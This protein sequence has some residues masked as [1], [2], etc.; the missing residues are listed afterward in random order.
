[1][2]TRAPTLLQLAPPIL[3]CALV[4]LLMPAR[5]L[6]HA[7]L[8]EESPS[9]GA[10]LSTSPQRIALDFTE[11]L[12]RDL[13]EATLLD[14]ESDEPIAAH[15]DAP[16]SKRLVLRPLGPLGR[17]PYTVHWRTVSTVDGHTLEGSFSFG[18]RTAAIGGEGQVVQS[19]LARDGWLRIAARGLFYL[20]LFFFAGGVFNAVLLDRQRRGGAWLFPDALRSS[21]ADEGRLDRA[22]RRTWRRT[23]DA[24]WLAAAAA[25]TVAL[26]EAGDAAGGFSPGGLNDYLL[27]NTAGLARVGSVLAIS[28]AALYAP[29][30]RLAASFWIVLGFLA[31]AVSGHA[32]SADPRSLAIVTD[33]LHLL[34]GAVWIGG[35]AQIAVAWLPL[36]RD[37]SEG[38]RREVMRAVLGRFGQVALPAFAFVLTTG[39]INALI[40][41]GSVPELW[42]SAYGRL[43]AAKIS[44]V[45]VIA[46]ASF[47]HAIRLRPRLLAANPHPPVGPERRHWRLLG[48]EPWLAVAVVGLAATLVAFPLPPRQ[49]QETDE[50]E[51]AAP[52]PCSPCS[53]R[54]PRPAEL[55]VAEQ[56]GSRIAA[57]YLRHDRGGLAG[58]LFLLGSD[59]EPV[60]PPVRLRG[61]RLDP[62]GAGCWRFRLPSGSRAVRIA[63][64]EKGRWYRAVVPARWDVRANRMARQILARAQATM[65]RLRTAR[66]LE[67]LTSGPGSFVRTRYE[68]Q[69]PDR[70]A[71]E[72]SGGA[73]SIVIGERQWTST[74]GQRWQRRAF[75]GGLPFRTR[76]FLRWTPYAQVARLLDVTDR[77][78]RRVAEVALFQSAAPPIWFRVRIDLDSM[79][80]LSDR[81]ITEGHFMHRRYGHFNRPLSIVP[82]QRSEVAGR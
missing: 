68:L 11:P 51:A 77:N 49:L 30:F 29:R 7:A 48:L 59:A 15:S 3:V 36:I 45:G 61:G 20:A 72:T 62:C 38:L 78:R 55:A 65:S 35:I 71:Y 31:I 6:G 57:V 60:N 82:P 47:L 73:R 2:S 1:M 69:A 5:A 23:I 50:A 42:Q 80:V 19:P 74:S 79:R 26:L 76:E 24:G 25:A 52:P 37:S 58:D 81:M 10:R 33:W 8:L 70:F 34:A 27:A 39:L 54:K 46:L 32:N 28:A 17:D 41:L 22:R 18:V 66:E 4:P 21:A 44:I 40:Q 13:S 75:G 14:A 9:A 67:R 43:L 12:N 63:V 16:S 64:R 56:A 53:L